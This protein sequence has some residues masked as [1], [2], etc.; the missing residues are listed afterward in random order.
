[1]HSATQKKTYMTSANVTERA[2]RASCSGS[3]RIWIE[4][5]YPK[6]A[7]ST[8][9]VKATRLRVGSKLKRIEPEVKSRNRQSA[10]RNGT[11]R[12][13]GG[14]MV[15]RNGP[16]GP[17]RKMPM[18]RTRGAKTRNGVRVN[19][20]RAA[21]RSM[22]SA[23]ISPILPTNKMYCSFRKSLTNEKSGVPIQV[24]PSAISKTPS[25]ESLMQT[26]SQ[27][28]SEPNENLVSHHE[29]RVILESYSPGYV[30]RMPSICDERLLNISRP[31]A[32]D[33]IHTANPC[34]VMHPCIPREGQCVS[35]QRRA[36]RHSA[37]M[38]LANQ[39]IRP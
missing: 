22:R 6:T 11:C 10:A 39:K 20:P 16:C 17:E 30:C 31:S 21:N 32:C 36:K 18:R 3:A 29:S 24:K 1:M 38:K 23:P 34:V 2:I 37:P 26:L 33:C 14:R 5:Q 27:E 15:R 19:G 25:A 7:T 12:R 4:M 9:S 13:M 35:Q 28:K 8:K